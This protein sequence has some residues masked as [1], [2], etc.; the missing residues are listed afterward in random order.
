VCVQDDS[1][2]PLSVQEFRRRLHELHRST[3]EPTNAELRQAVTGFA[4]PKLAAATLSEFLRDLRPTVLPRQDFVRAFVAGCLLHDD[5]PHETV[6]AELERWDALWTT[7]VASY[8][9]PPIRRLAAPVDGEEPAPTTPRS[10]RSIAR[11][12]SLVVAGGLAGALV[13]TAMAWVWPWTILEPT[14]DL[15]VEV[16]RPTPDM[17]QD[18]GCPHRTTDI[19]DERDDTAGSVWYRECAD[20]L[21]FWTSDH[22]KDGRC[23]WVIV[24]WANGVTDTTARSCPAGA[25]HY[26]RLDRLTDSYRVE[27][28]AVTNE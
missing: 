1:D 22:M 5:T 11:P 2:S 4:V 8:G 6:I 24:R 13:A 14:P 18:G 3:G 19:R 12:V 23:V 10:R 28:V 26:T 16:G 27:L 9:Q 21:E 25:M 17:V 7:V 20:Y 15:R